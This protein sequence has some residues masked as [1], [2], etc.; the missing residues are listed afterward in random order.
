MFQTIYTPSFICS[1]FSYWSQGDST[2]CFPQGFLH[3]NVDSGIPFFPR[4]VF[5]WTP[6][7]YKIWFPFPLCFGH[8][9]LP[10]ESG[11]HRGH[12]VWSDDD[13]NGIPSLIS[14]LSLWYGEVD[15]SC[16]GVTKENQGPIPNRPSFF[17]DMVR[18]LTVREIRI[19][20]IESGLV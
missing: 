10:R 5:L 12:Y 13:S 4:S 8:S 15:G 2:R 3:W 7:S 16:L 9:G 6:L 18:G 14:T 11:T 17:Q 20:R 1:R 19:T